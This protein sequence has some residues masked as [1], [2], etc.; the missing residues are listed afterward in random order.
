[1]VEFF[2]FHLFGQLTLTYNGYIQKRQVQVKMFIEFFN[3]KGFV[4]IC[5]VLIFSP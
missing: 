3:K 1:M 2:V 4:Y 5:M